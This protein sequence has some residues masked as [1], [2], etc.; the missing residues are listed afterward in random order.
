MVGFQHLIME[1]NA[2][3]NA[4][5]LPE[6]S[7]ISGIAKRN[8]HVRRNPKSSALSG[9][10]HALRFAKRLSLTSRDVKSSRDSTYV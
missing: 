3:T 9:G 1:T 4:A 7:R 6:N 2:R 10:C 8:C 5:I